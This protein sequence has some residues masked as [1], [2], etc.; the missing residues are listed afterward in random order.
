MTEYN[1][2]YECEKPLTPA[3]I[4]YVE[5]ELSIKF[6]DDFKKHYLKFNGGTPKN[7]IW[8]DVFGKYDDREVRDFIPILYHEAFE[9]DPSFTLNGR[10]KEEWSNA[11]VPKNLIPFAFDWVGNYF[12]L[13][14]FNQKIYYFIRDVWS[15]NLTQDQNFK[16]NS[17]FLCDTFERFVQSLVFN[18]EEDA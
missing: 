5:E 3:D 14:H 6:S 7:T 16:V 12:C 10:V 11:E 18:D 15:D 4:E 2:F 9:N 17:V 8:V 13:D 1:D